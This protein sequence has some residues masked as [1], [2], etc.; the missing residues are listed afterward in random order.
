M[1]PVST[2]WMDPKYYGINWD[3]SD[4]DPNKQ[5]VKR[6][7]AKPI[8]KLT[9]CTMSVSTKFGKPKPF[10]KDHVLENPY[11]QDML[12]R[13]ELIDPKEDRKRADIALKAAK[14][15][16]DLDDAISDSE[17]NIT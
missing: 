1:D 6:E 17:G 14:E 2:K 8:C 15:Q 5:V 3:A 9:G 16:Q 12:K 10:C 7:K 11:V 13:M 4:E